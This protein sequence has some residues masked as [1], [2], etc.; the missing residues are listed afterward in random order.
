LARF[1]DIG[2]IVVVALPVTSCAA[3]DAAKPHTSTRLAMLL[4]GLTKLDTISPPAELVL[5]R[6]DIARSPPRCST[7]RRAD[8]P[9]LGWPR[10]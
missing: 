6:R 5:L 9:Q 1:A 3:A 7:E 10:K 8:E 2:R 4:K